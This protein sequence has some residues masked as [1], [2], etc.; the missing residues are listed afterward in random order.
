MAEPCIFSVKF[1]R[2]NLG[3]PC[4]FWNPQGPLSIAMYLVSWEHAKSL[5]CQT[6]K[7]SVIHP[8]HISIF[9]GVKTERQVPRCHCHSRHLGAPCSSCAAAFPF[10]FPLSLSLAPFACTV[11]QRRGHLRASERPSFCS[12]L[13]RVFGSAAKTS[14]YEM[15][16]DTRVIQFADFNSGVKFEF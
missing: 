15:H 11:R 3:L 5:S 16:I 14:V 4:T 6:F 9:E 8:S 1:G 12:L 7:D 13:R 10:H 2:C